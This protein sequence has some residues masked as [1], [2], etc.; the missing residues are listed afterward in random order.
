MS[1]VENCNTFRERGGEGQ[2]GGVIK[3]AERKTIQSFLN[4]PPIPPHSQHISFP[5][6]GFSVWF[7][8]G[9][10]K[11]TEWALARTVE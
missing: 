8:P 1:P 6:G 10:Q 7:L 3:G 4:S 5:G 9:H 11:G 2:A